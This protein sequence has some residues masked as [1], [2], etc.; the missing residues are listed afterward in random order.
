MFWFIMNFTSKCD[1]YDSKHDSFFI[2]KHHKSLLQNVS[3]FLLQ[4]ATALLQNVTVIT[5]WN[6]CFTKFDSYYKILQ[7]QDNEIWSVN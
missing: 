7:Y 5:K 2:R 1:R 6:G 4:H 3:A